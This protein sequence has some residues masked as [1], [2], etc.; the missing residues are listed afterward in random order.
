LEGEEVH[1]G[2]RDGEVGEASL[3]GG[4]VELDCRVGG[5]Q[6]AW[7]FVVAELVQADSGRPDVVLVKKDNV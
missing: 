2:A 1:A 4:R 3:A 6:L 7:G 5:G